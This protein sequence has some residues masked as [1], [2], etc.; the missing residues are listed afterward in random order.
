M[1]NKQQVLFV[2]IIT[3]QI[4]LPLLNIDFQF[5]EEN[6]KNSPPNLIN[7]VDLLVSDHGKDV[8]YSSSGYVCS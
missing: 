5:F 3:E 4:F 1:A 7:C 6:E 8:P 2:S